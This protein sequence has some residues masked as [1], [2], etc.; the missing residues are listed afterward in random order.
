MMIRMYFHM[1]F[2]I[3]YKGN[4]WAFEKLLLNK[5][6]QEYQSKSHGIW[7]KLADIYTRQLSII[8]HDPYPP[9]EEEPVSGDEN[10]LSIKHIKDN[11]EYENFYR[12]GI[13]GGITGNHRIIYAVHNFSKVILLHYFDKNYNGLIKRPNIEPAEKEYANY[14]RKDPNL[15]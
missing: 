14:C 11:V 9:F 7:C 8:E 5:A 13:A 2:N 15:Y 1:I 3:I 6:N 12:W 10:S 4:V